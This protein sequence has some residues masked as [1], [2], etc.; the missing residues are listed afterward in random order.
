VGAFSEGAG[1]SSILGYSAFDT[2]GGSVL[3]GNGAASTAASQ[4]VVGS[5][6]NPVGSVVAGANVSSQ[7]WNV[8]ING[9]AQKILLA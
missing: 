7:Y 4:F 9:V 1:G 3:L 8:R 2:F 6:G 5:A